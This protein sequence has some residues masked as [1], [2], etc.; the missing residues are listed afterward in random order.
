MS[1]NRLEKIN[2]EK[3]RRHQV[4]T[5]LDYLVSG[6]TY[7]DFFSTDAFEIAENSRYLAQI[8]NKKQVTSEFLLLSFFYSDIELVK[9]LKNFKIT[10][11]RIARFITKNSKLNQ[12]E[13]NNIN[14]I[15]SNFKT[16]NQKFP[17][18]VEYSYELNK[19]FE[20]AA[21]NS[22]I[23]FK[24]PVI[25]SSILFITLLEE[26]KCLANKMLQH[27]LSNNID[28]YLLK[29]KIFKTLHNHE[30]NIR[31][32]VKLNQQYFAYLLK[33]QLT[34]NQF[35]SLVDQE[36]LSESVALFRNDLVNQ[37][38]KINLVSLLSKDI[39]MSMNKMNSRE[40]TL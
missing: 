18:N 28:R 15:L 11:R 21:E 8:C 24:T 33:T 30:S 1:F 26:K 22:L 40:Y 38:L 27:I 7:F 6:I 4:Y 5:T 23:R 36:I 19:L 9:F 35:T 10:E 34:D 14:K 31:S 32:T 2:L 13:K 37:S 29:Y 16:N 39:K 12:I 3:R 25:T 20:K 17:Q